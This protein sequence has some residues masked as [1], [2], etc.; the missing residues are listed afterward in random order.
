MKLVAADLVE[1]GGALRFLRC[2]RLLPD[3]SDFENHRGKPAKELGLQELSAGTQICEERLFLVVL[4]RGA[5][6][7]ADIRRSG[8]KYHALPTRPRDHRVLVCQRSFSVVDFVDASEPS[9][10][11][12][13]GTL[14]GW[15][16]VHRVL[17]R[18]LCHAVLAR[19]ESSMTSSA[20]GFNFPPW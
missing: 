4:A 3:L 13:A 2:R 11:F 18:A 9:A 17:G 16:P 7:K 14:M 6:F 19:R 5:C 8:R 15:P 12:V 10:R 20:F 1:G